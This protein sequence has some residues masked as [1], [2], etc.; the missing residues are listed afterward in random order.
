[1]I[2][3]KSENRLGVVILPQHLFGRWEDMLPIMGNFVPVQ[4]QTH[5]GSGGVI[6]EAFSPLFEPCP[7]HCL[8]PVYELEIQFYPQA[9]VVVKAIKIKD[10]MPV[11]LGARAVG[12]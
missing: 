3:T 1:M 12:G 10:A 7:E 11:W 5:W 2:K 4:A 8:P 6:L 9:P